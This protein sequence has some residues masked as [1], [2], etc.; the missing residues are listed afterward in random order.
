MIT[1]DLVRKFAP[2]AKQ[3]YVAAFQTIN[4]TL[5][6]Y[7][8][9]SPL[10]VAHFLAQILHE[11]GNLTILVESLKYSHAERLME[12][13]PHRFPTRQSALPYVYNSVTNP[14]SAEKLANFVYSGRMGNT[15]PDDGYKYIGR[16]PLQITGHDSYAQFGKILGI[17]LEDNPD[18]A[19]SSQW[20]F[21]IAAAEFQRAGCNEAADR[22]SVQDVS[23]LI[24]VGHIVKDSRSIVGYGERV[25]LTAVAKAALL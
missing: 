6:K 5:Q 21:H 17:P 1:Q 9:D 24:N 3:Q 16:G 2:L 20:T 15:K 19:I 22:D 14:S 13:W 25:K 18:L 8:I 11:S 23:A 10:R 7:G 4:E 12:V